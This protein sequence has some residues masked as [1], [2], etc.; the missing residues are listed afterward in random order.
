MR[1][2]IPHHK[3]AIR[4]SENALRFDI[5]PELKPILCEIITSQQKGVSEMTQLLRCTK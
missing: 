4:M 5:C 2:M 1:E 3:G